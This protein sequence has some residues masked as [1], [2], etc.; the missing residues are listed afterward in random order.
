MRRFLIPLR[1]QLLTAALATLV[2]AVITGIVYPL[3]VW[4]IGQGVFN[5]RANGSFVKDAK[6]NVV[7]SALIG[8]E[9][10]DKQ[11]NALSQYFQP[12]PSAAG[13]GYTATSSG[14]TNLGPGDPRL[15]GFIPGLNTVDLNGNTSATNPFATPD[16]PYCVPTDAKTGNPVLSPSSGQQFAK[17]K[18]GTYVCDSNTVPERA[19][20]YRQLNNL[21][22][23]AIV[24][25]DAVTASFSGL[26]PDISVANAD[27]QAA[28]VA[29]A[30]NLQL[31][32]VMALVHSHTDSR[33][34]GVIGEKT[35]N[36]L[37][38]NLALDR[39]H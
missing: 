28:R 16:D 37:D 9:F 27:L 21:D 19:I 15:V 26:D 10:L 25:V 14:A 33:F 39:L 3:A 32:Q 18:D 20:A 36:V 22:P 12:R 1:R 34:L 30:R 7:G 31:T 29:K 24:P 5:Y 2:L 13:T 17:N 23:K 11:G 4:A 35:I 6:G 8:Q 38:L